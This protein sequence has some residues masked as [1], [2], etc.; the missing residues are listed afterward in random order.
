VTESEEPRASLLLV[1]DRP[2]NL[3]AL[4]AI[5]DRPDYRLVT[6]S[7]GREALK[8]V[9]SEDFASILLDVQMPEMD[10]FE[11][12]ALIKERES[13]GTSRSSS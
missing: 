10:G 9:L 6:A 8:H 7:S 12:A 13:R 2:E 4:E 5:L 3:V 11:T 1:D